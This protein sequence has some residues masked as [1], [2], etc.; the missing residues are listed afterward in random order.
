M[1]CPCPAVALTAAHVC[2]VLLAAA[3]CLAQ[4][5]TTMA[6][7]DWTRSDRR[8]NRPL[9]STQGF[10]QVYMEKNPMVMDTFKLTNPTGTQTRLETYIHQMEPANDNDDP[11][12]FNWDGYHPEKMIRFIND[13][14]RFDR[15]LRELGM[16]PLSLLCYNVDWLNSGNESDPIRDKDEW[17]EF[18]A[19]VVESYNGGGSKYRPNLRYVEVW[20]EPNMKQFYTGTMDSYFDLFKRTADRIHRSYPGVMVGG[21]ALTHAPECH[22][23]EWMEAFIRECGSRADYLT[24]HPYGESVDKMAE[25]IRH[26]TSEF[27]KIPGKEQGRVMLTETDQWT[28]GWPKIQ[29]MFQRQFRFLDLSDMILGIHHFC[30][31]AYRE[32]GNYTF[33]IVDPQGAVIEGTFWPFWLFRGLTGN[34]AHSMRSGDG[35]GDVSLAASFEAGEEGRWIGSAVLHNRNDS[36]L[37]LRVAMFFPPADKARVLVFERVS[38]DEKGVEK[39]VPIPAGLASGETPLTL[40]PGEAVG[41]RLQESGRRFYPFGDIM[42]QEGPWVEAAVSRDKLDLGDTAE[43]RVRVLNTML[44]PIGGQ[45][46]LEGLPSGWKLEESSKDARVESLQT[47]ES[48]ECTFRFTASTV[49]GEGRVAPYAVFSPAAGAK[50]TQSR[51]H[52]IPVSLEFVNPLEAVVLPVPVHAVRGERN[53]VTLQLSSQV[54]Q[55]VKG[56]FLLQLPDGIVAEGVPTEFTMPA[57]ARQRFEFPFRIGADLNPGEHKGKI[58]AQYLGTSFS[59]EFTIAVGEGKPAANATPLDIAPLA[60][61]DAAAFFSNRKDYARDQIGM[62][63]YPADYTPSNRIVSI[64]GV[65]YRMASLEDGQKNAILPGG[66]LIPVQA[67]KYD[68]VAF[69]G[70]GHDGKHPGTW[71]FH[72]ADGSSQKVESQIPEWCSPTPEGFEAAFNAPHRYIDGGPAGPS[73]QLF[74]WTLKT[75]P[76]KT[77]TGI[78]LPS[79]KKAYLFAITLIGAEQ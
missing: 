28:D 65:P 18:A 2:L 24:Y 45:L 25:D 57:K 23:R 41:L 56:R 72:Y 36:P 14:T 19:A 21:P 76:A 75:D 15:T 7:I 6:V 66:E 46:A 62:F 38:R 1:K 43:V 49:N 32:S 35:Q 51:C 9:F 68:G 44:Q 77:L 64:R 40:G 53:Q 4:T 48:R 3:P 61:I 5:T 67:G 22:P 26:W 17:A 78:E 70:F 29:Y 33:G 60:N 42:N 13:R 10:M 55:P 16:E 73:C 47:G 52:S 37:A 63:V 59:M 79:L 74:T 11:R 34:E 71:I 30:C 20:N 50:D 31:L 39:V 8:V 69:M 27:R 54:A 12:K 58:T